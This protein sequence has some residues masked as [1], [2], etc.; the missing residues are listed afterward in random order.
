MVGCDTRSATTTWSCEEAVLSVCGIVAVVA[1]FRVP[2]LYKQECVG[3]SEQHHRLWILFLDE[4]RT[5][6]DPPVSFAVCWLRVAV[7]KK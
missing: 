7:T 4:I 2:V 6:A 1:Y 3:S 5:T